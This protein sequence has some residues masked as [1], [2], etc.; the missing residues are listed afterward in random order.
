MHNLKDPFR[1]LPMEMLCTY[2]DDFWS[3]NVGVLSINVFWTH[4]PAGGAITGQCEKLRSEV[5]LWHRGSVRAKFHCNRT[6][7]A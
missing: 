4:P 5:H 6:N 2:L 7:G 3:K 1:L